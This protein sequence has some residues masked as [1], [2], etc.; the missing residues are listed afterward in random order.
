MMQGHRIS[1]FVAA[2]LACAAFVVLSSLPIPRANQLGLGGA[3]SAEEGIDVSYF[4]DKLSQYG[5]WVEH[6]RFGYVWLPQDVSEDWRPYTVGHW[7][8]TK[9]YGWYWESD[10]PFA[11]AVY[12]YGR[13]G[14]DQELGW[15]WVPGNIWAPAWVEWRYPKKV[16]KKSH[17]GWAPVGPRSSGY[18][19]GVEADYE[20]PV[21]ESWVFVEPEYLIADDVY[22]YVVPVTDIDVNYINTTVVYQ[23]RY[24][25]GN[26][27]NY[28]MPR[29]EVE[30]FIGQPI[31]TREVV[32]VDD[33]TAV[34]VSG[35]KV[36]AFTPRVE[37]AKPG[38]AP[39]KLAK[40]PDEI[41]PKAKL[42]T[43]LQEAPKGLGP[44]ATELEPATKEGEAKEAKPELGGEP[45]EPGAPGNAGKAE[46]PPEPSGPSGAEKGKDEDKIGGAGQAAT[47]TGP[48]GPKQGKKKGK[49]GRAEQPSPPSGPGDKR[50]KRKSEG[51]MSQG[52]EGPGPSGPSPRKKGKGKS[53][54]DG[55]SAGAGPSGGGERGGKKGRFGEAGP[56][57]GPGGPGGGGDRRRGS[58][59]PG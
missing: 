29:D 8:N 10:E 13:W 37:K 2:A 26:V 59:E 21:A 36:Q 49:I 58:R 9:E 55:P 56:S 44:T 7:I 52:D 17:V 20:P 51:A 12:H 15:F 18:A 30:V 1:R 3:A 23:P 32:R 41:K 40:S 39:E 31:E 19:Y 16:S 48:S 57:G 50:G 11:W 28:G 22:D 5:Q 14:Y 34:S 27:Y 24:R 45:G 47:P 35:D 54:G 4:Y 33:P 25:G 6:P 42:K 46:T 43:A 38:M 53:A